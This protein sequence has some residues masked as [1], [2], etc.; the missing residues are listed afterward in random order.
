M[1]KARAKKKK[2]RW[3]FDFISPFAYFQFKT[4]EQVLSQRDDLEVDFQPILF[5]GLLHHHEHKGPAEIPAK[6]PMTYRYCDWYAR[7]Q[8]IEFCMPAAHPFNPLP[9]LRLA[10]ALQC[11]QQAIATLFRHVWVSSGADPTFFSVASLARIP[12][13]E[14][15]AQL[16]GNS[17]VKSQL[18]NNTTLAVT[19]G[20][21]GVPTIE[22]EDQLFWGVDMTE[23]ALQ[24]LDQPDQILTEEFRRLGELP[25]AK[26]R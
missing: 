23:M 24:Y 20:V 10:I 8:G 16:I 19:R 26:A 12:G 21:F 15:V 9:L 11:N 6:R 22:V 3:Y 13:F 25:V 5:A 7:K 14:N 1:S 17:E 18:K 4:L 2:I